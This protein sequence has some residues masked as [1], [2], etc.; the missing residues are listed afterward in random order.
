MNRSAS[1]L[2]VRVKASA[3][4]QSWRARLPQTLSRLM[5]GSKEINKAIKVYIHPILSSDGY[6]V[7]QSR[8]AWKHFDNKA[9]HF[10]ISAVGSYFSTVTGFPP[11]SITASLNIYYINF[12]DGKTV[13]KLDK[14][15][16]PLPKE[17]ECHFRF[18]LEKNDTQIEYT[19]AISNPIERN[20]RDVWWIDPDGD[21]IEPVIFDLK[22]TLRFS[23]FTIRLFEMATLKT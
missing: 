10:L 12:T 9:Y 22:K 17:T 1:N 16:L 21:N 20:R 4:Q 6:S 13:Q 3:S 19:M 14:N 15:G 18:P 8:K 2:R 23:T 11:M 7:I 5:I